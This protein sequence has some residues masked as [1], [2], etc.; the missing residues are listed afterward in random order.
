MKSERSMVT[1]FF[2]GIWHVIDGA[3]KLVLNLLFFII[4]YVFIMAIIDTDEA[5]VVEPDTAL[6]LRPFGNVVEQY[7]GTP[8]DYILMQ[9]A[10]TGR[11][12]TRLRDLVEAVH[13]AADDPKIAHMVIDPGFLNGIGLAALF[14]NGQ[15]AGWAIIAL[16]VL[17]SLARGFS[18]VAAKDVLGKTIPRPR[19]GRA[20]RAGRRRRPRSRQET[21]GS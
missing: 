13:R 6:I 10:E 9:A 15:V 5:L 2:L 11:T 14:L 3:R 8:L 19:R 20:R 18:S 7:S 16:L 12:E 21:A 1:R 17:F 4:A